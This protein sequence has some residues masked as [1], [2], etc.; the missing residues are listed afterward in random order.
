MKK[1]C[2]SMVAVS[3]LISTSSA[4]TLKESVKSTMEK[5]KE[6][7]VNK[8]AVDASKKDI[9]IAKGDYR[10]S[11]DFATTLEKSR[12]QTDRKNLPKEDWKNIG[13]YISTLSAEQLLY[14][15]GKTSSNIDERKFSA[16]STELN[17]ANNNEEIILELS[18]AYNKLVEHDKLSQLHTYNMVSHNEAYQ[19][20]YE[21][22]QIS[23]SM[24]ETKKTET[25]IAELKDKKILQDL[26]SNQAM[27]KFQRLSQIDTEAINNVCRP[28]IIESILPKTEEEAIA[29]ALSKNKQILEQKEIVNAQ[30]ERLDVQ[31]A[32]YLPTVKARLEGSYDDDIELEEDGV[33][34][35]LKGQ[36]SLNWNFYSGGSD[37]AGS[38]KEKINFIK[39]KKTLE[40]LN[41]SVTEL[42]K[43]L[44]KRFNE[45]KERINII[46]QTITTDQEIL[47]ITREQLQDGTKTFSDELE[48]KSKVIESQ[49]NLVVLE[50]EQQNIYFDLLFQLGL[51]GNSITNGEDQVCNDDTMPN[52][53]K[54]N[55]TQENLDLLLGSS[56]EE[57]KLNETLKIEPIKGMSFAQKLKKIYANNYNYDP[58]TMT[59]TINIS[60]N[61]FTLSK[62][63]DNDIF[64]SILE[65][66]SGDFLDLINAEQDKI[67][68]VI[69]GSHTSS[70]FRKFKNSEDIYRANKGLSERRANK[71]EK[72]F[73][74]KAKSKFGSSTL[75]TNNFKT[76]GYGSDY[77]IKGANGVEDKSASRRV[78][79]QVLTK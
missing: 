30:R 48:A 12:Q 13:G 23:G 39:E 15:G 65:S 58:E 16:K 9:E 43:D 78:T 60:A 73:A 25:L 19:I 69:I 6:V 51:L 56:V 45:T 42:V 22:E 18:K 75:V 62:V 28:S 4:L 26:E 27:L 59:A 47:K 67:K 34:K 49:S 54:T 8:L 71:V 68:K 44:Y 3:L 21:Q 66:F 46:K 24:L 7:I 33:Q 5:N 50:T 11:L 38:E 10:P 76:V 14:D 1:I 74:K 32:D 41:D 29:L 36:I 53:I 31:D 70:E 52:L 72:Y 63:N 77:T 17:S 2:L 57:E 20:A 35:K 40:N 79:I 37:Q 55:N 64:H 61:S